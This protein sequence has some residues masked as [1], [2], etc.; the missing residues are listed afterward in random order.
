[1]LASNY[2]ET[3]LD[4]ALPYMVKANPNLLA[5][6]TYYVAE[7]EL[8]TIVGCGGWTLEKPGTGEIV[9]GEAH[10]RHF[11][12]HPDCIKRGI[13]TALLTRCITEA[14][15]GGI[16]KLHCFSTLNAE[17][18]YRASGFQTIDFVDVRMGP[19]VEFRAV[20]MH[21]EIL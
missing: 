7:V 5:S 17:A 11:A 3:T 20:L 21:R 9:K 2:D 15:L 8:G 12:V 19:S 4:S 14:R 6:G 18:F 1:L 13:G 10:I 16:H